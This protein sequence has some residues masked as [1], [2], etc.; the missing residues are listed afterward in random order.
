[1]NAPFGIALDVQALQ[2][3]GFSDRGIGRYV[4]GYSA[5]LARREALAAVLLAPELPPPDRLPLELAA[6]GL[7][8]WDSRAECRDLL[9]SSERRVVYHVTAPFL[10]VGRGEPSSLAVVEHW[11]EAAAP[12]VVTLHDLIPLRAP[13]HY[14]PTPADEDRYRAR[15]EWIGRSDLVLTNSEHTRRE[16][17]ELLGCPAGAV[18]TVGA[19]VS[20]YFT[21]PD[22]TDHQLF[23]SQFPHLEG[24][25]YLLTVGGDDARKGTDRAVAALAQ[26]VR[27]GLDLHLLVVGHVS[28]EWRRSL[29]E[30]TRSCGVSERVTL[31]G[32]VS[33]ELLRACYR[34]AVLTVT[35][36]LAEGAGLPVLESA[37]CG[38]PAVASEGTALAE[39]AALAEALFDA[40]SADA[41]ADTI[42]AVVADTALHGRLLAAQQELAATAT[43]DAVA[44]RAL[45]ALDRSIGPAERHRVRSSPLPGRLAVVGPLPPGGGGIGAYNARL[46]DALHVRGDPVT[47]AVVTTQSWPAEPTQYRLLAPDAFGID[48]RPASFDHV[49][50]ALGNSSGHTATIELALRH[51]GWI[52]LHEVRL[53]AV[54]T[55]AL[56]DCGDSD[57]DAAM[58]WL[59]H[60]AYPGRAPLAAAR[61]AGRDHLELAGAGVG[62]VAPLA[63]RCRGLLVNSET[64]R[65]LLLLDLPPLA[66]LPP[67]KVLPPACPPVGQARAE[68]SSRGEPSTRE[69]S[70]QEPWVVAFGIVS[71]A[72]RPDLLVDAAVGAGCRVAF[73]GP[74]P[75]LLKQFIE[76]RAAARGIPE[77][78]AVVGEVDQEGWHF[79][80]AQATLAVQLRDSSGGEM[81][82][83]VL[84][85]LAAGVPVLTNLAS[86]SEYPSGTVAW[87]ASLDAEELGSRMAALISSRAELAAL[88]QAGTE[89]AAAHQFSHL[90]D[91]VME[92]LAG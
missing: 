86:A 66:A 87:M 35:P 56:E 40:R 90:A 5:A 82:A 32:A 22:G 62:L 41:I 9:A 15:A 78:I 39:T 58:A 31:A 59:L 18:V 27:R 64:A 60:R 72:K 89:F 73:V 84:E 61:R 10:H 34:R 46:L 24:R 30:V 53:P 92:A 57:F 55:T 2:A 51:P 69:R 91:A 65:Q 28:G 52:W 50:Y 14:L 17:I 80:M 6:R 85:A 36:S 20:S 42:T 45:A 12:R 43:W 47:D 54:A 1:M 79:W 33:D 70:T 71:M 7:V 26:V 49:V 83:A 74:C 29:E 77:R 11:A 76:E 67:I 68:Q 88:S 13:R 81:S 75:A 37:A 19:G 38:T 16:A 63:E 48:V 4:A 25:A 8:R 23:R 21:P 44:S 3:E